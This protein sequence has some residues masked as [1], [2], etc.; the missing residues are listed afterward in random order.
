M[1]Q[2]VT[3]AELRWKEQREEISRG[4]CEEMLEGLRLS[5]SLLVMGYIDGHPLVESP[6]AF[7]LEASESTAS[8]LG[9]VLLLDLVIRNGDRLAC[10]K[11]GWRGNLNNIMFTERK[12]LAPTKTNPKKCENFPVGPPM[13]KQKSPGK[14]PLSETRSSPGVSR[15]PQVGNVVVIDSGV[16]RRPPSMQ[17]AVDR[18]E[19]P[20]FVELLLNDRDFAADVLNE[21]SNG[22]FS[23]YLD[24]AVGSSPRRISQLGSNHCS[25]KIVNAFQR[26]FKEGISDLEGLQTMMSQLRR[27]LDEMLRAFIAY[28]TSQVPDSSDDNLSPSSGEKKKKKPPTPRSRLVATEPRHLRRKSGSRENLNFDVWP[29][30]MTSPKN[31]RRKSSAEENLINL[32]KSPTKSPIRTKYTPPRSPLK[33]PGRGVYSTPKCSPRPMGCVSPLRYGCGSSPLE[34]GPDSPDGVGN[35]TRTIEMMMS[36]DPQLLA[37]VEAERNSAPENGLISPD[38]PFRPSFRGPPPGNPVNPSGEVTPKKGSREI[39]KGEEEKKSSGKN[40]YKNMRNLPVRLTMKIKGV[41][42]SVKV[43]LGISFQ[44]FSYQ[45]LSFLTYFF[46]F[47]FHFFFF[48][49]SHFFHFFWLFLGR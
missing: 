9:R 27:R 46:T 22:Q 35:V 43:G 16:C 39:G 31:H 48:F 29:E 32:T 45:I 19:Y 17:S 33:S 5:R 40:W 1:C 36:D 4:V 13:R 7:S 24:G 15:G 11:L 21:I 28:I 47:V 20:V 6:R 3:T 26:G 10:K 44:S 18:Q 42:K 2:A 41:R 38:I 49:F 37:Q 30:K 12:L 25:E 8:S 34:S 14:S 23:E